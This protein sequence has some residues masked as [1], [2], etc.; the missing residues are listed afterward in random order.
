MPP[1]TITPF[2]LKTSQD[3]AKELGIILGY[4]I[5]DVPLKLRKENNIR[6][7]QASLAIEGNTLTLNQVTDILEGKR[8]IGPSKDILEVK[9]ALALYE[10]LK[11]F[12]PLNIDHLLQAHAIL[13]QNLTEENGKWRSGAVGIFKGKEVSHVAPPAK[14]VP[15][16]MQ[17]L[18]DFLADN[19]GISWLIKACVFHYELEFIHPFS[20]GNGRMGRLWQQLILM[21]EDPVF[22]YISLEVLVRDHQQEYYDVLGESD[23]QGES[24]SF[25]EF[26]LKVI[27][28]ALFSYS[29]TAPTLSKDYMSR[30]L[31][32]KGKMPKVW[33]SRKDYIGIHKD[34]STATASRDLLSGIKKGILKKKGDKNQ[35]QY[36]FL[37]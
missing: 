12:D 17:D 19:N 20:N 28:E 31:Y 25:I 30:L 27:Y 24:T 16:L 9:N 3:I 13:M 29:K 36:F 14:K 32:A 5:A 7:I 15:Q 35:I 33:F 11:V 8:V 10:N 37:D 4:K 22:E 1:F 26:S 18:F 34:I 21:K 6:S 23:E 2:I